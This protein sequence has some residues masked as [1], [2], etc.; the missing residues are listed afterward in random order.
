MDFII[1]AQCFTCTVPFIYSG[2]KFN[3]EVNLRLTCVGS[4]DCCL[5]NKLLGNTY[6]KSL[7]Q[8]RYS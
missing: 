6:V 3:T 1:S 4:V 7:P 8:L 2:Y 5:A